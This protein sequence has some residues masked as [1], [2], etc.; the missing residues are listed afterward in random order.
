VA[1][2]RHEVVE[3]D[4]L[5]EWT[6]VVRFP[7]IE[8]ARAFW[9]DPEYQRVAPIRRSGSRSHVVLIDG[10]EIGASA[11]ATAPLA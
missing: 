4:D 5:G 3:G 2:G 11:P 1:A 8:A 9:N 10:A 7:T 6:S